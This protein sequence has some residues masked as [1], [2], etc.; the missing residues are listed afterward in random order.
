VYQQVNC[1]VWDSE[2]CDEHIEH[3]G[4]FTKRQHVVYCNK[5]IVLSFFFF[6]FEEHLMT[7]GK[8]LAK[9]RILLCA[10]FLQKWLSS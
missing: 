8:L 5:N 9:Q 3:G 1:N 6:F 4:L 10:T 2:N 7:G